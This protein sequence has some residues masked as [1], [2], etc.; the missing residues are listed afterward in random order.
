MRACFAARA[1]PSRHSISAPSL[2]ASRHGRA[3]LSSS[4]AARTREI[5]GVTAPSTGSNPSLFVGPTGNQQAAGP[6]LRLP[7]VPC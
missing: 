1:V 2:P 6:N 4:R 7:V 3:Y 5:G